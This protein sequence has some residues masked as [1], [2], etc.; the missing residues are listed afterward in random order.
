MILMV[1]LV[2]L[3]IVNEFGGIVEGCFCCENGDLS[4]GNCC[5]WRCD[6][7]GCGCRPFF[8]LHCG[9]P[10]RCGDESP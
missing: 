1:T 9:A 6:G 2:L 4:L 5:R 8:A 7:G 10:D 3:A